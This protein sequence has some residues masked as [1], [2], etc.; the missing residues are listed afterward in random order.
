ME[1]I[2]FLFLPAYSE[3]ASDTEC[4]S[5]FQPRSMISRLEAALTGGFSMGN[6]GFLYNHIF[7][8]IDRINRIY[9]MYFSHFPE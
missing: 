3:R 1:W 5:G 8:F 2:R 4:G 9:M 6:L 7:L